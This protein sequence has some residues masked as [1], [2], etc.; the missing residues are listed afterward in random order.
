MSIDR[1]DPEAVVRAAALAMHEERWRDVAALCDPRALARR[2]ARLDGYG[3]ASRAELESLPPAEAFARELAAGSP[4]SQARAQV[5][6]G[7]DLSEYGA[8]LLYPVARVLGHARERLY[9]REVAHVLTRVIHPGAP[10]DPHAPDAASPFLD[11]EDALAI[12][13]PPQVTTLL[14]ADDGTWGIVPAGDLLGLG[15]WGIAIETRVDEIAEAEDWE[16]EPPDT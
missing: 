10:V 16:G 4:R 8:T 13:F 7:A 14:R 1:H 3:V 2:R 6:E 5:G 11:A 9:S 12:E 15:T